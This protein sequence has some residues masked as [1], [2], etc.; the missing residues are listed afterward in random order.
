MGH[1][2]NEVGDDVKRAIR[3]QSGRP[4]VRLSVRAANILILSRQAAPRM[5]HA[6]P[7]VRGGVGPQQQPRLQ[8]CHKDRAIHHN[9]SH[10]SF[11]SWR[12][13]MLSPNRPH[14]NR[15]RRRLPTSRLWRRPGG[16]GGSATEN[17]S[18][19]HQTTLKS[20]TNCWEKARFAPSTSLTSTSGRNAA[21]K[22]T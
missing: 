19:S 22:V 13:N 12:S 16:R 2:L 18:K 3:N 20:P 7:T 8:P 21:V 11:F 9:T 1:K 6:Q 14:K 15:T 10:N 4:K 5:T 17:S